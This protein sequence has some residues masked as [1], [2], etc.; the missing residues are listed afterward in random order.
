MLNPIKQSTMN[1]QK[2]IEK[3]IANIKQELL[4]VGDMHPG[5][6][7]KQYSVC[8]K[9]IVGAGI[10]RIPRN[11]GRMTSSASSS[12][13]EALPASSG[14]KSCLK[15][16]CRSISIKNLRRLSQSGLKSPLSSQ[17]LS[18]SMRPSLKRRRRK[19]RL[20]TRD[21]QVIR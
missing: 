6:L 12:K 1:T 7:S 17:S 19:I 9:K 3:R 11:T 14:L 5:S 15:F 2:I 4:A 10:L 21:S 18:I 20:R 13:A 16:K 8:G